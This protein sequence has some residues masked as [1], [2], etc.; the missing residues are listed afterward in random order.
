MRPHRTTHTQDPKHR[1]RTCT[2]VP[3][4]FARGGLLITFPFRAFFISASRDARQDP[5]D[6]LLRTILSGS[7]ILLFVVSLN[8]RKWHE[9]PTSTDEQL[10]QGAVL[11]VFLLGAFLPGLLVYSYYFLDELTKVEDTTLRWTRDGSEV[12]VGPLPPDKQFHSFVSH[13]WASAQDQ[14]KSIKLALTRLLPGL[15]CFL[16]VDDLHRVS[17]AE[18]S[19]CIE[20]SQVRRA[21]PVATLLGN[22]RTPAIPR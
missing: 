15:S 16:D 2:H 10:Q 7:T 12:R 11:L 6:T 19:R 22:R 5:A 13:S 14:A 17:Q 1:A 18:M 20:R 8:S 4:P 3:A 21:E 9:Q